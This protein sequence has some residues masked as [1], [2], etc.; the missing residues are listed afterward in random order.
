[1]VVT[2]MG[3]DIKKYCFIDRTFDV[4][5][6][7]SF[8][9]KFDGVCLFLLL[10]GRCSAENEG[11]VLEMEPD[12]ILCCQGRISL[13]LKNNA[14]V[15]GFN[16]KGIIADKYAREVGGAFVTGGIFAPFLPRQVQQIVESFH[17]LS[18]SYIAN[19]SFE[20]LNTLSSGDRKAVIAN[21]I[22]VEALRLIKE[23]YHT[24]Y[25]VEEL[26]QQLNI[27]K[28][29]LVREFFKYTGTTPGKYLTAVR[30][31]AVKH[32]LTQTSL[33]LNT[34]AARTGFS[35]DNYLCKAF[36]KATGETPMAY[37]NRVIS[38]QYLPNQLTLQVEPDVYV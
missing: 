22:I 34:I 5:G 9:L 6:T 12:S 24:A 18:D 2:H 20:I 31:D 35:G 27:S 33:P 32:L 4:K 21:Q 3:F 14:R 19:I 30:I 1:M 13:R 7:D 38:S 28:S 15:V 26:A 36:K 16:I 25:G 17:N 8:S 37:K 10:G 11:A 23:N 29:H